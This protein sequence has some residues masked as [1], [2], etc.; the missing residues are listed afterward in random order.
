[1]IDYLTF[2]ECEHKSIEEMG[3]GLNNG[4]GRGG[5][6]APIP[7]LSSINTTG[8]QGS[9]NVRSLLEMNVGPEMHALG[10]PGGPPCNMISPPNMN[11]APGGLR[12]IGSSGPGGLPPNPGPNGL[13]NIAPGGPRNFGPGNMPPSGMGNLPSG[14]G[15]VGPGVMGGMGPGVPGNWGTSPPG[16]PGNFGV[17]RNMGLTTNSMVPVSLNGGGHV[18]G[19]SGF[20]SKCILLYSNWCDS[21]YFK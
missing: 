17:I 21:G 13:G 11:A 20:H 4:M 14:A 6:N 3:P 8:F 12:N 19:V 2:S 7:P 5:P 9:P 18:N 10:G 15:G 16:G 1:M